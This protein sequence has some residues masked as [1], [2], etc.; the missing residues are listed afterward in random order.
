M[1][2]KPNENPHTWGFDWKNWQ[3]QTE[4]KTEQTSKCWSSTTIKKHFHS[5][6]KNTFFP[7]DFLYALQP[8]KNKI[9]NGERGRKRSVSSEMGEFIGRVCMWVCEERRKKKIFVFCVPFPARTCCWRLATLSKLKRRG[10]VKRNAECKKTLINYTRRQNTL[11]AP[12]AVCLQNINKNLWH[13][14]TFSFYFSSETVSTTFISLFFFWR[15]KNSSKFLS[16]ERKQIASSR[17][18]TLFQS[19]AEKKLFPILLSAFSNG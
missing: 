2:S 15:I 4:A 7:I 14:P 1:S 13:F 6:Q 12:S 18:W 17:N 19:V 11:F 9:K 3:Q 16:Q 8:V 10:K 5:T